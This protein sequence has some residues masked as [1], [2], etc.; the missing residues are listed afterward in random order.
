MLLAQYGQSTDRAKVTA[1]CFSAV[2]GNPLIARPSKAARPYCLR[3]SCLSRENCPLPTTANRTTHV[4]ITAKSATCEIL[5][6][7]IR[8]NLLISGRDGLYGTALALAHLVE[9]SRR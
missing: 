4:I 9:D 7:F 8:S 1:P 5:G 6:F 3:P 2:E